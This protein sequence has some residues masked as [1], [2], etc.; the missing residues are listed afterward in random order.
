MTAAAAAAAQ[1]SLMLPTQPPVVYGDGDYCSMS[2]CAPLAPVLV[3]EFR[4]AACACPDLSPV[5][6]R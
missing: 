6:P 1:K 4:G 3:V 2:R 5:L